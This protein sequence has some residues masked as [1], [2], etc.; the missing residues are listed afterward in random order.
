[1]HGEGIQVDIIQ[2]M[3]VKGILQLVLNIVQGNQ[4][5]LGQY[6]YEI[7]DPRV[8]VCTDTIYNGRGVYQWEQVDKNQ[9]IG[10]QAYRGPV[11][12]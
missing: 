2:T 1:M 4:N 9:A 7:T 11:L 8:G 6:H 3:I 10:F 12:T 5:E